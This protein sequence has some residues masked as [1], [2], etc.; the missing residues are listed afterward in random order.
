MTYGLARGNTD[1]LFCSVDWH[2]ATEQSRIKCLEMVDTIDG[3]RLLNSSTDELA[4]YFSEEHAFDVPELLEDEI[5]A[6]Q[7]EVNI[8]VSQDERRYIRDRSS[9]YYIT[10]TKVI[11]EIPFAGDGGFFKVQP[12][13][14]SLSPPRGEVRQGRVIVT[15]SGTDLGA[16]KV[17][18]DVERAIAD[19]RGCL[20]SHRKAAVTFN[21][22]LRPQ[23]VQ[24]IEQRKEK[25]LKDRNLVVGLGFPLKSRDGSSKTYAS[26][27]VKKKIAPKKIPL[28]SNKP[29][30]PP[31]LRT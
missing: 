3:D 24:K 14:F 21:E 18:Q 22:S 9:S 6:D 4:D 12:N 1:L 8:D 13:P 10:G 31:A 27:S 7:Q 30:N 20:D 15:I 26:P 5:V 16:E 11:I 19:I 28:A 2:S 17:K 29:Y 25:L 23:L